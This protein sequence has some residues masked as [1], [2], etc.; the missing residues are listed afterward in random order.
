[1]RGQL[2]SVSTGNV[3]HRQLPAL[4]IDSAVVEIGAERS[5]Q[6]GLFQIATGRQKMRHAKVAV[7]VAVSDAADFFIDVDVIRPLA[8]ARTNCRNLGRVS[9]RVFAPRQHFRL[10]WTIRAKPFLMKGLRG[11]PFPPSSCNDRV[12]RP[13]P[14]GFRARFF[15]NWV[16][17]SAKGAMARVK[18]I[19]V[20]EL[21]RERS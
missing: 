10:W 8:A 15:H 13:V 3:R 20:M 5:F 1:M 21:H 7:A 9:A 2:S 12:E 6:V 17:G 14:E 19:L 16:A 4:H 11:R 18:K